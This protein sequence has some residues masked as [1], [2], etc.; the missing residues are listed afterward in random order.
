MAELSSGSFT[1]ALLLRMPGST[2]FPD[3]EKTGRN[4]QWTRID[5]RITHYVLRITH[6]VLRITH[7]Y[8][9]TK[10]PGAAKPQANYFSQRRGGAKAARNLF[11]GLGDFAA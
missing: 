2:W 10:E 1:A 4:H 11:G 8:L 9:A 5:L 3:E 6:Y 7:Y